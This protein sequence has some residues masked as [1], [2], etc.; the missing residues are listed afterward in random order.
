MR[1]HSIVLGSLL[2][3]CTVTVQAQSSEQFTVGSRLACAIDEVGGIDCRTS[4]AFT[5]LQP[6]SNAPALTTMSAGDTHVCG[7]TQTGTAY[8]WGDN[9]FGQLDAPQDVQF[10]GMSSGE[11]FSCG[12]TTVNKAVCWGLDTHGETE[13]PADKQYVQTVHDQATSCGL[14]I[15]GKISCWGQD[16]GMADRLSQYTFTSIDLDSY[17]DALCGVTDQSEVRC[18][19]SSWDMVDDMI[20]VALSNTLYCGLSATG[21]ITCGT[22]SLFEA[23]QNHLSARVAEINNGPDVV[24]LYGDSTGNS[25]RSNRI[26]YELDTGQYGCIEREW[27]PAAKLPGGQA[28]APDA[29]QNLSADVYSDSTIEL[30]WAGPLNNAGADIYRDSQLIATTSNGSSYIDNTLVPGVRYEYAVALIDALGNRSELSNTVSVET[31]QVSGGAGNGYRPVERPAEPTGLSVIMYSQYDLEL[32]W[33][34]LT[35]L[36]SEF[37]G[38]EIWRNHEFVA[39]TRGVS[40][41]DSTVKANSRYHYDVVAVSR[42]G[43]ILG[44]NGIDAVTEDKQ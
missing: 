43:T 19:F 33:D 41:Y 14:Q 42:D 4:A 6:P 15:D 32:F 11:N 16:P 21:D 12:I 26:C 10:I 18:R 38:Y 20:D 28:N 23:W 2:I 24:A 25:S 39:F 36:P 30:V 3:A 13:P 7:I 37:N 8:C 22:N 29:A 31:G 27:L 40:F 35:V 44:F 5:R 34:R 9:N 1:F 17:N